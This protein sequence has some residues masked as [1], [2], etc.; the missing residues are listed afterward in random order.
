MGSETEPAKLLLPYLQRADELQKHE[1]LV[2]YYCRLYA[3]ER[4]LKINPKERTKTT[5]ALLV[6]LMKQLEKDKKSLKLGPE[7]NLHVEGFALNVF[8]KAD[9]QDRA[10][11]ADLNTAKTFYAASIFFEILTQFGELQ[12]DIEQKQKYAVWKAAEIRKALKEGRKPEPGPPTGD[13]DLSFPFDTPTNTEDTRPR[14]NFQEPIQRDYS[15]PTAPS[16]DNDTSTGFSDHKTPDSSADRPSS[17]SYASYNSLPSDT[18]PPTT[19][20]LTPDDISKAPTYHNAYPQIP[21][22]ERHS[23]PQTQ[24]H[25]YTPSNEHPNASYTAYPNYQSYPSFNNGGH[26]DYSS[27]YHQVGSNGAQANASYIQQPIAA[28]SNYAPAQSYDSGGGTGVYD[29]NA[30]GVKGQET[31]NY[32]PGPEKIAEAHKA[33]RFAVGA[34]AFDDVPT[35]LDFLRRSL[36]LLTNPSAKE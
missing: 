33:A 6:S 5:N 24:P 23:Q 31:K 20:S 22:H 18:F 4:G 15:S 27:Y 21:P 7:D 2:A 28:V 29:G 13:K 34:L 16:R 32:E 17:V 8:A 35:A 25:Q 19:S 30:H 11:R 10:G 14:E 3:M 36:D 26:G 1:P 12:P 9:K